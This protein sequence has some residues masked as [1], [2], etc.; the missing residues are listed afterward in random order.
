MVTIS[1]FAER[2]YNGPL[3]YARMVW[4]TPATGLA[5]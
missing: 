1:D 5:V 2:D 4:R 3:I